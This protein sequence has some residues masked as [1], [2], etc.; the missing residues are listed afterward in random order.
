MTKNLFRVL[1][2]LAFGFAAAPVHAEPIPLLEITYQ[3]VSFE[4]GALPQTV[5]FAFDVFGSHEFLYWQT[6]HSPQDVGLSFP[7]P[8]EVIEGANAAFAAT[9]REPL[10]NPSAVGY[11]LWNGTNPFGPIFL[12]V[13]V[14]P[15]TGEIHSIFVS[16]VASY[17]VTAIERVINDFI[18]TDVEP[19]GH[20]VMQASQTIRY[21][22]VPVP[23]PSSVAIALFALL[24]KNFVR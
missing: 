6:E 20:Y 1:L 12:D 4:I 5:P 9:R 17:T 24:I 2:A 8:I 15:T 16:D 10:G 14:G 21:W 18:L 22:G 19:G 11:A 3:S 23:E 7:A 13:H